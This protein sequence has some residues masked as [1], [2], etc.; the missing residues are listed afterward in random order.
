MTLELVTKK[1]TIIIKIT[2]ER[3]IGFAVGYVKECK[4]AGIILPFIV[5][6]LEQHK[7]EEDGFSA[8]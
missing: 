6:N 2:F 4:S 3:V 5:I 7:K 8:L 1:R